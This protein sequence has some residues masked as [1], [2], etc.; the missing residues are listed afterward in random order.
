MFTSFAN[1]LNPMVLLEIWIS[2]FTSSFPYRRPKFNIHC[3]QPP[4]PTPP[5]PGFWF[6]RWNHLKISCVFFFFFF[7][8][9][10]F[11]QKFGDSEAAVPLWE[12]VVFY[13]P[14]ELKEKTKRRRQKMWE[15]GLLLCW[16]AVL[17]DDL[18]QFWEPWPWTRV[19]EVGWRW[20]Q[21]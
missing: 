21:W 1:I 13:V 9:L 3:C 10:R 11:K 18:V 16:W 15:S 8:Q 7:S 2:S 12:T 4:H 19:T 6:N 20:G 17:S 14:M 5:T